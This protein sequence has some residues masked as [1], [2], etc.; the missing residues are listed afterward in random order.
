MLW[1]IYG[2]ASL[3]DNTMQWGCIID[4]RL[5]SFT[6]IGY[7]LLSLSTLLSSFYYR[8][9]SLGKWLLISEAIFWVSKLFFLKG[10]Y[11][12]GIAGS[13]S[14]EVLLFDSIALFLRLLL[15][16]Q[17]FKLPVHWVL[18]LMLT[19]LLMAL[20]VEYFS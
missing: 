10:G 6:N 7:S 14:N 1:S 3:L 20:K 19:V 15:L 9:T 11:V 17:F 2:F 5:F 8:E 16:K 4:D 12:T 13:F 18:T